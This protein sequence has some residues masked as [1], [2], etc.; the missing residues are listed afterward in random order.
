MKQKLIFTF[1]VLTCL[2]GISF[3][4]N[5]QLTGIV[6]SSVDGSPVAG[7]SILIIGTNSAT[8]T[9]PDG[10]YSISAPSEGTLA[11][12]YIG[13]VSQRI[14]IGNRTVVNVELV[15]DQAALDEVVVVGYGTQTKRET[16]GAITSLSGESFTNN[17]ASSIDRNLQ[18]LA[19]GVQSSVTSGNLSQPAK[20]RIRGLSSLSSSSD[21]LYV[22]DGVPFITGDGSGVF[23]NNPLS[24]I[25]PD[26]IQSVEVL[27]D[28]A[29]TAIFGSRAAGGVIYITTKSGKAGTSGVNYSNWFALATPSKRYDLLN[30]NEFIEISNEKLRNA[31]N[32]EGAFPTID[33]VSNQEYDTD[34]QDLVLRKNAFQQNHALALNG[35]TEKTSYY[36]SGGFADLQGVSVANSQRKYNIRGK[37]DQK[38]LNDKLKLG[39]NTQVSYV[40]DRG[41]NDGGSALSGNIASALYALPNV[42]SQWADGSY[43]FSSDGASLGQGDNTRGIDG[44]YTNAAYTLATN[45]YKSSVFAFNGSAYA[46]MELLKGLNFKSQLGVQYMAGEDYLYWNP[47]HGDGRSVNG[48]VYQ[49]YIPRSRYNWQNYLSYN[50]EFAESKLSVVA[51]IEAQ[52]S[53][54]RN[55]FAHGFDL[56][57]TYFAENENIISGSLNSQLIGGTANENVFQ[58]YFGRANYTIRD[59]YF[60]SASLRQD[61]ISSLPHGNQS[62]LLPGLSLGWDIAKESFFQSSFIS[63][64]K[65]RGGYATVGNTAIGNY[66]YAGIFS[67]AIYGDYS[68]IYYSQTGNPDLKF[69][70]SKKYNLGV[71]MAFVND[72]FT[73]TADYFRNNIDNMVLGVPTP[74]SLGVPGNSISQN[75]GAM[76]NQGFEITLGGNVISNENFRWNTNINATFVKNEVQTLFDGNDITYPYHIVREG[77]SAGS[78][79]GYE[80]YGVNS[81]N[82]NAVY[83]SHN[84]DAQGNLVEGLVQYNAVVSSTGNTPGWK[85]YNPEDETDVSQAGSLGEKQVLGNSMPTWYGG[86]NNTL[87]YK[88]FDLAL[89]FSFSGGNKVFNRTRQEVLNSQTFT[90]AGTE[91]LD[92]WTTPGQQ[93]DVPKLFYGQ[94]ANINQV[95]SVTTRFL[96]NGNFLRARTIGLGY[97]FDNKAWLTNM[98]VKNLRLFANVENAFVITNYSGIDPEAANSFTT[99]TQGAID[100]M[101]NPIPRTFTFGLNVNF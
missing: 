80:Y 31:G 15:S 95:N 57:S 88:G 85:V 30:A 32:T 4:Q 76:Y 78:F 68:G 72:R 100:F 84:R 12:S 49:Y 54:S 93:T 55:F 21:P 62:V 53:T 27:K 35:A 13:F 25:N 37:V 22:I 91:L 36:F 5:R 7:V 51:G 40:A 50:V 96:E 9:G 87:F 63:Q 61:R 82:G 45:I 67:A 89:N 39:I 66:P 18:G 48:R 73:L 74:P 8:Q 46:D 99:N 60:L 28:G 26:D 58:A 44:S 3:A 81:A 38:A 94:A 98:H 70:T 23:Y 2:T 20:I 42:P 19:A 52:K 17:S 64:F 10:S 34:W 86:F 47:V 92:R 97:T 90:N 79:F 101:S 71:D 83:R 65:L 29:A 11:V 77:E 59:R 41:F 75:V 14:A 24:S 1:L 69:E 33:P 6:T 56:S 16:T 43:N